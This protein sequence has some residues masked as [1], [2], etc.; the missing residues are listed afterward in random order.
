MEG[1]SFQLRHGHVGVAAF[2]RFFRQGQH[3][4]VIDGLQP[5]HAGYDCF[6]PAAKS[7]HGMQGHGAGGND[8]IRIG[9]DF[10]DV[11]FIPSGSRTLV[12]QV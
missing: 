10:I 11:D 3:M 4:V 8:F 2:S 5:R 12:Y 7:G 6:A 1:I 9:H